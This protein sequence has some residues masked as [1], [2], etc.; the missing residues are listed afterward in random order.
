KP[1]AGRIPC[2]RLPVG[3]Y[4]SIQKPLLRPG[5]YWAASTRACRHASRLARTGNLPT[6]SLGDSFL[7][8]Y[9]GYVSTLRV[10]TAFPAG[11]FP[12]P[13]RE[14]WAGGAAAAVSFGKS[15]DSLAVRGGSRGAEH[16]PRGCRACAACPVDPVS[17]SRFTN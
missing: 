2:E 17:K 5:Q 14:P 16:W 3:V 1:P 9:S 8:C 4:T 6:V 13:S 7:P 10:A 15:E 11:F 12:G